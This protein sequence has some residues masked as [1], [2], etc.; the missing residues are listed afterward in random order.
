MPSI[1]NSRIENTS[2]ARAANKQIGLKPQD[3][4]VLFKVAADHGVPRTY[5]VLGQELGMA[6]SQVHASFSRA[7]ASRLLS[8]SLDEV[9]LDRKAFREFVLHGAR[10]A[11]PA[12]MGSTTRGLP[13]SYAA[14]PLSE[15]IAQV[16]E[17]PP[18]WEFSEGTTKGVSLLPL[19]PTVP[20]AAL[21]DRNL[22]E[23]LSLFD[24]LR[25]GA[26]REREMAEQMLQ[27]RI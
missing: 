17:L 23:L 25:S 19:Y 26:A 20:K 16:D 1:L 4:Y 3:L 13:T 24:A 8:R 7:L 14:L 12:S 18:V 6:A 22:Y 10:Y 27:S 2:M 9:R 21:K 11:F 15:V 5:A